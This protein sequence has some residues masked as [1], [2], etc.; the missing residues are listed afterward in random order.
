MHLPYRRP[1]LVSS[2][3]SLISYVQRT[4]RTFSI[5]EFFDKAEYMD[6]AAGEANFRDVID[7]IRKWPESSNAE[8][9]QLRAWAN[10]EWRQD[11]P[12]R[13]NQS[14]FLFIYSHAT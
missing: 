8:K 1:I 6:R 4:W 13:G 14:I 12:V 7:K 5:V 9:N 10:S 2:S 3:M 11:Y